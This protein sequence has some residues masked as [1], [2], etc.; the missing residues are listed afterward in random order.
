MNEESLKEAIRQELPHFLRTDP[1]L[2][3]YILELTRREYAGREETQDRFYDILAELRRD[4][5]EQTRKW[6]VNREEQTRKW[7]EQTRKWEVNR[8]EQTRKWE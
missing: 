7:E 8:E 6:E 5:E 4:R 1:E 3:A 2:R